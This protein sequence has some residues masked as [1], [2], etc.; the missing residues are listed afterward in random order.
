MKINESIKDTI[1]GRKYLEQIDTTIT[2][3][4]ICFK[5]LDYDGYK[6]DNLNKKTLNANLDRIPSLF[7]LK[8]IGQKYL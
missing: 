2:T 1:D 6:L 3:S 4:E 7:E 8:L 5:I